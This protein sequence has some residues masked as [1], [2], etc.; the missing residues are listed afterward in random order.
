[1]RN[2]PNTDK[3]KNVSSEFSE[4]EQKKN[5][6]FLVD[7]SD[8]DDSDSDNKLGFLQN[9]SQLFKKLMHTPNSIDSFLL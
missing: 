8:K 7:K 5:R 3:E 9:K 4:V 2:F 1:M 6:S